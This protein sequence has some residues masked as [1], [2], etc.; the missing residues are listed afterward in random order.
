MGWEGRNRRIHE[1]LERKGTARGRGCGKASIAE[2]GRQKELGGGRE[3]SLVG[4]EKSGLDSSHTGFP[5]PTGQ[6]QAWG[7]KAARYQQ[8]QEGGI[9]ASLAYGRGVPSS[10]LP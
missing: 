7:P 6:P 8:G 5:V 2:L 1:T 3:R 4:R 9:R 10:G